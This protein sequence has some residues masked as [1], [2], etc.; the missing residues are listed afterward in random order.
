LPDKID[1]VQVLEKQLTAANLKLWSANLDAMNVRIWLPRFVLTAGFQL[2]HVLS[3]LGMPLAFDAGKADFS[4]MDGK[5]DLFIGAVVHKAY[6][7]VNEEGTEAAAATGITMVPMARRIDSA[8]F[9]ADHPFV[10]FIRD[11]HSGCIL[12][13]GRLNDPSGTEPK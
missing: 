5:Q 11:N 12:F 9:R 1:G 10:F 7:D 13:M 4:G 8:E 3:E 6:V 2:E